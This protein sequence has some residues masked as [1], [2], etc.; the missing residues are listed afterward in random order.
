[1]KEIQGAAAVVVVEAADEAM[2]VVAVVV[3]VAAEAAEA[4]REGEGVR[5]MVRVGG[6]ARKQVGVTL[7][8]ARRHVGDV[9]WRRVD[10]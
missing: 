10:V 8:Q 6:A 4:A 7:R 1:M 2:V 5:C 3:V 9:C